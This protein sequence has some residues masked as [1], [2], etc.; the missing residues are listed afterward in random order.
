MDILEEL[1][2]RD[3][4][5]ERLERVLLFLVGTQAGP[6]SMGSTEKSAQSVLKD[7]LPPLKQESVQT[8][9]EEYESAE[10]VLEEFL[11]ICEKWLGPKAG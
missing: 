2:A 10:K 3:E 7:I 6:G 9:L 1:K 11:I 5:I 4:R 8:L